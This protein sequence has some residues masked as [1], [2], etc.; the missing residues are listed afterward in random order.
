MS[1]FCLFVPEAKALLQKWREE[2]GRNSELI[3]EIWRCPKLALA[4]NLGDESECTFSE[5]LIFVLIQLNHFIFLPRMARPRAGLPRR[6]RPARQD[7]GEG[8]PRPAAGPVSKEQPRPPPAPD[9]QS[10]AE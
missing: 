6:D 2:N 3:R 1:S 10:G 9:G 8:V 5:F 4:S 7:A